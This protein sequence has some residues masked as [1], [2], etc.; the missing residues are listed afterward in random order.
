MPAGL[1][2]NRD[3]I[4]MSQE[5]S[6]CDHAL[7]ESAFGIKLRDFERELATYAARIG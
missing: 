2:F 6:V 7:V 1:R 3:Q 4:Q 5:D